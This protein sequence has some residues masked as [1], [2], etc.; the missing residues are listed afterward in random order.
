MKRYSFY[1]A[2]VAT[3]VITYAPLI[4]F[5]WMMISFVLCIVNGLSFNWWSLS[6]YAICKL[7]KGA[8]M[9]NIR[10]SPEPVKSELSKRIEELKKR[11]VGNGK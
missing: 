8:F 2:I 9:L 11:N 3:I 1:I 6:I 7:I 4:T 5:L 10:Q